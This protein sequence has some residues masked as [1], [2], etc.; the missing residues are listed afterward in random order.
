MIK[1]INDTF[2]Y[3]K[4]RHLSRYMLI[5]YGSKYIS[6]KIK[7]RFTLVFSEVDL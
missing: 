4:W 1:S 7:C 6:Y 2:D 3:K 5:F